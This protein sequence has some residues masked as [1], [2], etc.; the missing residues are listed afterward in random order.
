MAE[1]TQEEFRE[2]RETYQAFNKL[3]LF[4]ILWLVLLLSTMALGLVGGVSILALLL[5]VGGTL[6]LVIGFAVYG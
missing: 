5:G 2:H 4:M 6:A 3:V 1:A